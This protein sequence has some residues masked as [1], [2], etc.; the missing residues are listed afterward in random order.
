MDTYRPSY[1]ALWHYLKKLGGSA[2]VP[3]VMELTGWSRRS[4]EKYGEQMIEEGH[5][6]GDLDG[7]TLVK[8]Q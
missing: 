2:T 7:Y 3:A 1:L 4:V 6:Y 8:E 5:A